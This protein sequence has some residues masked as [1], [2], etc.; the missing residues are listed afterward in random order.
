MKTQLIGAAM[1]GTA[2]FA[3]NS[4]LAADACKDVKFYVTNSHFEQREI[5][6]RSIKFRNRHNGSQVQSEDVKNKVCKYGTTCLTDGDDLG[7]ANNVDL[8]AIQVVFR[9]K[10]HDGSW[11]KEFITQPFSP[12][13]PKCAQ[14]KHYGPVV[15]RDSQ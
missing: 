1:V 15:V 9:H 14:G 4:A 11:S 7:N 6:I 8:T 5:E 12:K 13:V 10:N 2:L 3:P